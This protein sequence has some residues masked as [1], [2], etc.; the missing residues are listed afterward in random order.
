MTPEAIL[1][2]QPVKGRDEVV[3]RMSAVEIWAM[4]ALREI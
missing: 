2:D 3:I 4:D 1:V